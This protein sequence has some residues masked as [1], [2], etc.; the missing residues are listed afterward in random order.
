MCRRLLVPIRPAALA[1]PWLAAALLASLATSP[2]PAQVAAD[3]EFDSSVARPAH[4]AGEGPR[5]LFD[6]AHRNLHTA[7]GRYAVVAAVAGADGFR[8]EPGTRLFTAESL[9]PGALLLIANAR[10][11]ARESDSA[12]TA[13]E[14]AA[15]VAWVE[16]GGSLFLIADHAPYGAAAS[17]LGAAFG[18]TMH[19][20]SVDDA[21]HQAPGMP[22]PF[23][24][25]FARADGRLGE[26]PILH[27]R[28]A[29]ERIDT[30]VTFGGQALELSADA[31][32]LLT[33]GPGARV[34]SAAG[35]PDDVA[36]PVGGWSQMAAFER[37]EGRVVVA[38]EA[39][40]FAAQ[41]IR[42]EAA[43][44]AGVPD[45]F[46]F[47]MTYPGADNKQLL[48]NTLRWLARVY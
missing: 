31:T 15:V 41:V 34:H 29:S 10:G 35:Q 44:R 36:K 38:G 4:A 11:E 14:I 33:F 12:F 7:G 1:A 6:E 2:S 8:V 22:G 43:A 42:G 30:V 25:R 28:D 27:G 5:L 3:Q 20:G 37:G 32:S 46:H 16:A 24:L 26:H 21:A 45:P 9:P 48:L 19:D 13:E 23:F 40:M 39:G 47:G 17:A 18:V